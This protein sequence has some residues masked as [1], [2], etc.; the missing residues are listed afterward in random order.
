MNSI[1]KETLVAGLCFIYTLQSM[2]IGLCYTDI[3]VLLHL[4]LLDGKSGVR[5][6]RLM[7][8][9][10]RDGTK[11]SASLN[12]LMNFN[13][14]EFCW[15]DRHTEKIWR[16]TVEGMELSKNIWSNYQRRVEAMNEIL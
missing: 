4:M 6:E 16:L 10:P 7:N 9:I 14:V 11:I 15:I 5:R 1:P 8:T 3:L 13:L 2:Q 12:R